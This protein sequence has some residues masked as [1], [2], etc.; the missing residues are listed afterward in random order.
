MRRG[1]FLRVNEET[2]EKFKSALMAVYGDYYGRLGEEASKAFSIY[3]DILTGRYTLVEN[4]TRTHKN[5]FAKTQKYINIS[6]QKKRRLQAILDELQDYGVI[7]DTHLKELIIKKTG[8]H[9]RRTIKDY[10]Q[11]LLSIRVIRASLDGKIIWYYVQTDTL[12]SVLQELSDFKKELE[13]EV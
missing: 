9:D 1:I 13:V 10:I 11:L 8:C 6:K 12:R 5:S 2:Y 3:A 7:Q 4:G